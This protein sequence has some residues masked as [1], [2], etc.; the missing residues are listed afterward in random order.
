MRRLRRRILAVKDG[1]C[2]L[3]WLPGPL[4][5]ARR[6]R[7]CPGAVSA[8]ADGGRRTHQLFF[9]RMQ[10]R[11]RARAGP[12][13]QP[14][15]VRRLKPPPPATSR[16]PAFAGPSR[17]LFERAAGTITRFDED[18]GAAPGQSVA[19]LGAAT[20]PTLRRGPRLAAPHAGSRSAAGPGHPAVPPRARR[21]P[22]G[23]PRCIRCP[24]ATTSAP[25]GLLSAPGQMGIAG[26]RPAGPSFED[27]LER[28]LERPGRGHCPRGRDLAAHHARRRPP[29]Q[30]PVHRHRLEPTAAVRPVLLA[31][32]AA[33]TT[34]ARSPATTCRC[35]RRAARPSGRA[36]RWSR[37]GRCSASA[38]SGR[39]SSATRPGHPGRPAPLRDHPAAEPD[40][41][42]TQ[43]GLPP[44]RRPGWSWS[45]PRCTPPAPARSASPA[46]R[47]RRPRQ[48]AAHH[49][50]PDPPARRAHPPGPA[51]WL[52]HRRAR[53]PNTA[54]PHLLINQMSARNRAGQHRLL[55]HA[56]LRGQ[57][58][59]LE[60]LRIDRQL[61]EAIAHGPDP[62]HLA[63]CSAST[64]RPRSAT[65]S[66]PGSCSSQRPRNTTPPLQANPRVQSPHRA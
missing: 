9:A 33:T 35:P 3:C 25:D 15:A 5:S 10:L 24:Q 34:C 54:N 17:A 50:R 42:T 1:Y 40:R 30:A 44:P 23:T 22:S 55:R 59:T 60:R 61:E 45:W 4:P 20:W 56:A 26:R 64:P 6:R 37:C 13:A 39:R 43:P 32:S 11:R 57:A 18:T 29:Q 46:A 47:R 27:W 58:A 36:R 28:K 48:P 62:L 51:E 63:A 12:A 52:E 31:W 7:R 21:Q 16:P 38:R 19:G 66:T 41:S 2:R 8:P 53:W 14:A 49:R 65:R